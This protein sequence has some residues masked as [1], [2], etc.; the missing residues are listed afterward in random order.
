MVR[1]FVQFSS[2]FIFFPTMLLFAQYGNVSAQ[3][4]G[5]LNGNNFHSLFT[6]CGVIAQPSNLT[7]RGTWRG[8]SNGYIGDMSFLIGVELPLK[9]YTGDG[10]VDTIHS[11]IIT[12]VDRPGGGKSGPGGKDYTFE[13]IPGYFNPGNTSSV[14]GIAL[15]DQPDTWPTTWPD[16]PEWGAGVWNGLNGPNTFVGKQEAYFVMDDQNDDSKYNQYGFRP[17][18]VDTL[19]HG[20]GLRVN[21]RYVQFNNPLYKDIL[22]RI[23]DIKNE[24]TYN[25]QKVVFGNLTGTYIG[26]AGDEYND[27]ASLFYPREKAVVSIDVEPGTG[28]P[29][30]HPSANPNWKGRVGAFS[31]SII[32][33][34]DNGGIAG[35]DYFVPADY[36][37]MSNDEAM[38]NSII[39]GKTQFPASV[40]YDADSIPHASHG[41]DGDY[42]FGSG[43]FPMNAGETKRIVTAVAFGYSIAET[44]VLT[45]VLP[46]TR[47]NYRIF[48]IIKNFP[49]RCQYNGKRRRQAEQLK[50]GSVP[51]QALPGR[52]LCET[53]PIPDLLTGTPPQR[54][55]V[56]SD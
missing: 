50:F 40:T 45:P 51:M 16:H 33:S 27:D 15:S 2:I 23:Y 56:H 8:N 53:H 7:P 36:T 31:E 9:D 14:N 43:Y 20:M 3:R 29:F 21:V 6:N 26:G 22:F 44:P 30:V 34:P 11:V 35:F 46:P 10:K 38:W 54:V 12:N 28:Q 18:T 13:P 24:G 1:R 39:P 52:M 37:V 25:Y 17:S 32:S 41:E 47:L 5:L 48:Y 42:L 19:R 4:V 55:I 49:A